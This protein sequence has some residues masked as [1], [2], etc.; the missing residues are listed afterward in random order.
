MVRVAVHSDV[1]VYQFDLNKAMHK[2]SRN[3]YS[4]LRRHDN[5]QNEFNS[6][7]DKEIRREKARKMLE[8]RF[9]ENKPNEVIQPAYKNFLI[10]PCLI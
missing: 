6:L 8:A 2:Y 9:S 5:Y 4:M 10:L 1:D 7:D 3:H